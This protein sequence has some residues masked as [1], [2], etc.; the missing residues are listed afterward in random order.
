MSGHSHTALFGFKLSIET[1][2]SDFLLDFLLGG[3]DIELP[4]N[5]E[6]GDAAKDDK[7]KT[8]IESVHKVDLAGDV[9]RVTH[10]LAVVASAIV[11]IGVTVNDAAVW[12]WI[13]AWV[14]LRVEWLRLVCR[15]LTF[16]SQ[17]ALGGLH[18]RAGIIVSLWRHRGV[19][20]ERI[21]SECHNRQR[22]VL[23]V[24][25]EEVEEGHAALDGGGGD[26]RN[27]R[28]GFELRAC[29]I[30]VDPDVER[31]EVVVIFDGIADALKE[32]GLV[33]AAGVLAPLFLLVDAAHRNVLTEDRVDLLEVGVYDGNLVVVTAEWLGD[34]H[35]RAYLREHG[36]SGRIGQNGGIV[37]EDLRVVVLLR[38]RA[39]KVL[40]PRLSDAELSGGTG[41][42]LLS[43]DQSYK[44]CVEKCGKF[45][46]DT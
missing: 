34:I 15:D 7:G 46:H 35:E 9:W 3:A 19:R 21:E 45:S 28:A 44:H 25:A 6:S 8:V 17:A 42:L 36:E 31:R 14:N 13:L 16:L 39:R 29:K 27:L 32:V 1:A 20:I 5:R 38:I 40:L 4:K 41:F 11:Q 23:T 37:R 33:R 30:L 22:L 2:V 26:Q 24:D 18:R 12:N 43:Q 10:L